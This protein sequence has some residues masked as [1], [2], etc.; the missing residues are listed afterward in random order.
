[1]QQPMR[2]VR[3]VMRAGL[4]APCPGVHGIVEP[5]GGR[6]IGLDCAL[7][8]AIWTG[9][10]RE[11]VNLICAELPGTE[12]VP[13]GARDLWTAAGEPF[14]RVGEVVEVRAE[15]GWEA[16]PPGLSAHDLRERIVEAYEALR[17]RLPPEDQPRLDR[18]SG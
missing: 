11:T 9:M 14:A 17:D 4:A 1:M 7:R 15:A 6:E 3:I 12:K 13:E 5:L 18:T 10:S 2:M 16:L 8:R